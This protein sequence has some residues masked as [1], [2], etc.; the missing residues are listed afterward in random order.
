[1]ENRLNKTNYQEALKKAVAD[2][3]VN[4]KIAPLTGDDSF[5]L[6]VT[7]IPSKGQVGAHYHEEGLETY[8]ILS[9]KGLMYVGNP[10]PD[11]SVE[12]LDPIP[13]KD[14][15]F[16]TIPKRMVH[17]L[18]NPF[19]EKLVLVFGC[20]KSHLSTDRIVVSEKI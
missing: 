2:P 10:L 18:R 5:S 8:Q 11:N 3:K 15:D 4:I 14:G 9:G 6:F 17:Q 1:M 19:D 16:F 12:W 13:V 7:E 20:P